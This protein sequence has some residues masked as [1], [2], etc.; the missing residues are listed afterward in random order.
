[1]LTRPVHGVASGVENPT[2]WWWEV[3]QGGAQKPHGEKEDPNGA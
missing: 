2:E 3:A 1:M